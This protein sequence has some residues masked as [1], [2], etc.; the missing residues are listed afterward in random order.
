MRDDGRKPTRE[1]WVL[2]GGRDKFRTWQLDGTDYLVL[3]C[4]HP[5]ANYPWYG[6]RPDGSMILCGLNGRLG[7]AFRYLDDAMVGAELDH[8]GQPHEV[9]LTED[10]RQRGRRL[11]LRGQPSAASAARGSPPRRPRRRCG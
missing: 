11:T 1:R 9:A 8:A 4:G 2:V 7:V 10:A 6:L 3:H 5:T